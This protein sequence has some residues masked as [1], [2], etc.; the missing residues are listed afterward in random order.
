MNK[1]ISMLV[2][3]RFQFGEYNKW[4]VEAEKSIYLLRIV[5]P[6]RIFSTQP[7]LV[8]WHPNICI[9]LLKFSPQFI[10]AYALAFFGLVLAPIYQSKSDIIVF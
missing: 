3:D 10:Q 9:N 2:G 4:Q 6:N 5:D 8:F 7:I 1:Q